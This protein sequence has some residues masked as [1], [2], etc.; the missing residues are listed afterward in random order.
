MKMSGRQIEVLRIMR[1]D[2]EGSAPTIHPN[3]FIQLKLTNG[4]RMHFWHPEIPRQ[5]YRIH[6]HVFEMASE[7]LLGKLYHR[8]ISVVTDSEGFYMIW[9][10]VPVRD[11]ETELVSKGE[12]VQAD[13]LVEQELKPGDHYFSPAFNFHLIRDVAPA[14]SV[15]SKGQEFDRRPRV[16]VPAG[17][18]P[19]NSFTRD[20]FDDDFIEKFMHRVIEESS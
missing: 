8:E 1:E 13:H 12:R 2:R 6:D 15:I 14:V 19:D 7:I 16:L 18:K 5:G 3:G 11:S 9:E 20:D 17:Q 4:R 10:A